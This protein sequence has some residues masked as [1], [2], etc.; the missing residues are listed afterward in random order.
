MKHW[1]LLCA[2]ALCAMVVAT[3][4][5]NKRK[6]EPIKIDGLE[7]YTDEAT[8]FSIQYPKNWSK[9]SEK[10][11]FFIV[12]AIPE[13][14]SRF[15]KYD[16]EG[17]SGAKIDVRVSKD[18]MPIKDF[19]NDD[20]LAD[21]KYYTGPIE[22]KIG[23]YTAQKLMIT[24]PAK[25]GNFYSEKYYVQNDSM[26]TSIEFA[27]FGSTFDEYKQNF[28]KVMASFKPAN[29]PIEKKVEEVVPD[30]AKKGPEPPSPNFATAPGS[31][32][33]ISIPDNFNTK[34][35]KAAGA[36]S[37]TEFYG[38]RLDCTIRVDVLDASKQNNIDKIAN[39][40]KAGF[41]GTNPQATTLGGQKAYRFDYSPA[42]GI[43][44]R[45]YLAVK[46]G[47]LYRVF[48]TWNNT[49]KDIYLPV[50]EKSMASFKFN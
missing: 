30:T 28:E 2:F 17:L 6:A 7:T 49:E 46:D 27:A 8:Q 9:R 38:G 12:N 47:K 37:G 1:R 33:S 32:F 25:D 14:D 5:C 18:S 48:V 34:G 13:A 41:G 23:A 10:G 39:D 4:S 42:A 16:I 36:L 43:S 45:A 29:R 15:F 35:V 22:T 44:R 11:K 24:F 20:K 3:T 50:F 31:G 26:V 19:I 21:D 40:N